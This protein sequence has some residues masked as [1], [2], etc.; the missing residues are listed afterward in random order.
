MDQ[1]VAA[2][3][4]PPDQR[5]TVVAAASRRPRIARLEPLVEQRD[6]EVVA[7]A[8]VDGDERVAP[9]LTVTTR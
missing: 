2:L 6:L 7:H 8:A 9:R 3:A 5:G 1:D 4:V